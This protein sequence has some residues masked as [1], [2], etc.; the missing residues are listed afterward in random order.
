MPDQSTFALTQYCRGLKLEIDGDDIGWLDGETTQIVVDLALKAIGN[1]HGIGNQAT[2]HIIEETNFS[3]NLTIREPVIDR[4]VNLF[5]F[6]TVVGTTAKKIVAYLPNN[7]NLYDYAL[8]AVFKTMSGKRV[9]TTNEEEWITF[10]KA[11]PNPKNLNAYSFSEP[12][13]WTSEWF[14]YPDLGATNFLQ[15]G[16]WGYKTSV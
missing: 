6:Y 4:I 2:G 8:E 10:F 1:I 15:F 3:F 12:M 16:Y 7:L 14:I 13:K 9:V 5:P 11:V